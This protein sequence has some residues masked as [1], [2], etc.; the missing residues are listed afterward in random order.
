M[1][2]EKRL[3]LLKLSSKYQFAII[4]DDYDYHYDQSP[5]LLLAS[6]DESGN[7]IYIGSFSK[8]PRGKP[9]GIVY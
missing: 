4:E 1:P 9:R 6:L 3:Q 5:I 7:T 2:V 8:Q